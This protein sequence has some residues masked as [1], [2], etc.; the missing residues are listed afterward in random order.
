LNGNQGPGYHGN[1][2]HNQGNQYSQQHGYNN[3]FLYQ[4][5]QQPS[6][7]IPKSYYPEN[8]AAMATVMW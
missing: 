6:H 1:I 7:T 2:A 5:W 3:Q 8:K 4:N